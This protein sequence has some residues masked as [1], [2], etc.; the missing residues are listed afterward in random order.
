MKTVKAFLIISLLFILC[1]FDLPEGWVQAGSKPKSYEM[2]IDKEMKHEGRNVATI[3]SIDNKIIGFGTMMQSCLP[4]KYLGKRIRFSGMLKTK[5]VVEWSAFW[6]RVDQQNSEVALA[7]DNMH[8]GKIDRS[9]RGTTEWK[10]YEI[11]LDVPLKAINLAYG[12]L[13]EGTGQVWFSDLKLEVVDN[14]VPLTVN[15][16]Y[17]MPLKEPTNLNFGN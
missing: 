17:Y 14:S 13:L 16:K 4:D 12:V 3:K 9:I 8:E 11:V 7:F 5:D 10:W 6:F 1:S 15:E 2:G